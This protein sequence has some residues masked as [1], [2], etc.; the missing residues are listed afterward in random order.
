MAAK[1]STRLSP[2]PQS[3]LRAGGKPGGK[4]VERKWIT[5]EKGPE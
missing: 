5:M 4:V 2:N 3:C 1:V